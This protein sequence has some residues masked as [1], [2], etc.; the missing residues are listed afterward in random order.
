VLAPTQA[1]TAK[2]TATSL[3]RLAVVLID[4]SEFRN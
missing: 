4:G 2:S 3:T 1:A